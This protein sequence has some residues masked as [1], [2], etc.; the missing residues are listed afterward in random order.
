MRVLPILLGLAFL[1]PTACQA[2]D[3]HWADDKFG[4]GGSRDPTRRHRQIGGDRAH[5][6]HRHY[7]PQPKVIYR[8]RDRERDYER[9]RDGT[10]VYGYTHR[11]GEGRSIQGVQTYDRQRVF[12]DATSNVVCFPAMEAISAESNSEDAAWRDAQRNW[13]NLSR[14]R[15]GER[16]MMVQNARGITKQCSR[17]SGNQSVAG[18]IIERTAEA[19][20]AEGYKHRCAIIA[21]PC[22]APANY[23][24]DIKGEK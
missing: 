4:E 5:H 6:R 14:W 2:T 18:K 17:S 1:F 11:E 20:G 15:Y 13:E 21:E 22:T 24:A 7:E 3:Y 10:R 9:Y 16:A 19:F 23:E 12:R 8:D